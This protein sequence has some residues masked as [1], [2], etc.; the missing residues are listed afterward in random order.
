MADQ[1]TLETLVTLVCDPLSLLKTLCFLVGFFLGL[2]AGQKLLR[3]I[4]HVKMD[5]VGRR[6]MIF[7]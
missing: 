5:V 7:I 4:L 1:H 6:W 3:K 2:C